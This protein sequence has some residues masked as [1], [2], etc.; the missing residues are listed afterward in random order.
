M[1]KQTT[2]KKMRS[3]TQYPT[4]NQTRGLTDLQRRI[5]KTTGVE[6]K[7]QHQS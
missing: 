4:A 7:L 2:R 5:N 3:D 1:A 6:N